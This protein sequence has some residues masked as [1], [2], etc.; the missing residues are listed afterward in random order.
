ME[1]IE[2]EHNGVK[3]VGEVLHRDKWSYGI[4]LIQPFEAWS[5]GCH[6]PTFGRSGRENKSFEGK[7]GDDGLRYTLTEIYDKANVFFSQVD[8]FQ[9]IYDKDYL[10][11][12]EA[13]KVIENKK[14]RERIER[15]LKLFLINAIER[16]FGDVITVWEEDWMLDYLKKNSKRK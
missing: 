9:R 8:R 16:A 7:R 12:L 14:L 3:L 6:I 11:E 2:V 4:K 5:S 13:V 1:T 10:V 15:K